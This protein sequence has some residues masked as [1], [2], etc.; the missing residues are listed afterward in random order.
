M[1]VRS[2]PARASPRSPT[3]DLRCPGQAHVTGVYVAWA[4]ALLEAIE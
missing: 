2:I 4:K 1:I 3:P